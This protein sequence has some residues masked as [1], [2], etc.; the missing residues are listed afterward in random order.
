MS[1]IHCKDISVKEV[2][3]PLTVKG[4]TEGLA[5][6]KVYRRSEYLVLKNGQD[7][8]VLKIG[9]SESDRLFKDLD[10]F[11]VVS[12]PDETVLLECEDVDVLNAS[13]MARIQSLHPG[14]TIV[15]K[16]M[17][18]HVGLAKGLIA[19]RI[20]VVDVIPPRPSKLRYFVEK[21]IDSG[22]ID[23][24]VI[25]EYREIDL[26]R[27]AEE[28]GSKSVMFPCS[29]SE[30]ASSMDVLYLDR[31]PVVTG[32]V[33]LIGCSLS[34]RIFKE[35]YGSQPE[36]INMCPCQ[37]AYPGIPTIVKCCRIKEGYVI[38]GNTV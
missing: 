22:L 37:Y 12:L 27:L 36:L 2:D 32:D 33:T 24:P 26:E 19:H 7:A 8:S 10:S 6:W 15:V 5:N 1:G 38:R 34:E 18:S 20:R 4:I 25:P 35:V 23:H 30:A 28:S 3:F 9:A 21:A 16:G 13:S 17:F 11:E 14:K 31:T 29:A